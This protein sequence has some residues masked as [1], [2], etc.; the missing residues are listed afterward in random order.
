MKTLIVENFNNLTELHRAEQ[1]S[2]AEVDRHMPP[3]IR[4]GLPPPYNSPEP[5]LPGHADIPD[6][7]EFPFYKSPSPASSLYKSG[8]D[9]EGFNKTGRGARRTTSRAQADREITISSSHD[10][11]ATET[12]QQSSVRPL[13]NHNNAADSERH[14]ASTLLLQMVPYRPTHS[15]TGYFNQSRLLISAVPDGP[16]RSDTDPKP[17]MEEATRSV[18]LLLDKW[19]ASGS[20]PLS[21]FLESA[22]NVVQEV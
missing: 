4:Q 22:D 1:R 6:M 19:T 10:A 14:R 20:A 17:A 8:H 18:R 12:F 13:S 9:E 11:Q 7:D 21:T 5:L 3:E 2:A 15:I 16:S